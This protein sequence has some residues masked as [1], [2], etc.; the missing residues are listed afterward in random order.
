MVPR[1][2]PSPFEGNRD[3]S[4]S[5]ARG[6]GEEF[7]LEVAAMGGPRRGKGQA[8]GGLGREATPD[9]QD[10]FC[11]G[12]GYRDELVSTRH[13]GCVDVIVVTLLLVV[14]VS[15][16][17]DAPPP[18]NPL[19]LLAPYSI[20]PMPSLFPDL[21]VATWLTRNRR[22]LSQA[23]RDAAK[24][25]TRRDASVSDS[26]APFVSCPPEA[27]KP[28]SPP[29]TSPSKASPSRR[30]RPRPSDPSSPPPQF[31]SSRSPPP[32]LTHGANMEGWQSMS[33]RRCWAAKEKATSE[34]PDPLPSPTP[35]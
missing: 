2:P 3:R 30:S 12:R 1:F 27:V 28:L 16:V 14:A 33:T 23:R 35:S 13:A 25:D 10:L 9:L 20:T 7:G 32:T 22:S 21:D 6:G 18:R 15:V 31:A 24:G 11:P 8:A 29:P 26:D 19:L 17:C 34:L 4:G 5:V